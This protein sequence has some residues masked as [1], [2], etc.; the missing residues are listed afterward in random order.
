MSPPTAPY[1]YVWTSAVAGSYSITAKAYDNRNGTATSSPVTVVV[2][3]NQLPV[4]ALTSPLSQSFVRAGS[5]ITLS[6]TANDADGAVASIEFFDGTTSIG[7]DA[8]A[9]YEM[10][11]NAS[12]PGVHSIS[13]RAT[14]NRGAIGMSPSVDIIVGDAPVVVVTS[15]VA[16]SSVDG[17][18]DIVLTADA[19]SVAGTIASVEFFDNGAWVAAAFAAPWRAVLVN[20][21]IG[22]HAITAQATDDRD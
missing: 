10:T 16:C 5:P 13:A 4:V 11:W 2:V 15:P 20:A 3:N 14:D 18:L 9:P 6:A 17:P 12:T 7:V 19:L 8:S 21:S 1:R 22:S